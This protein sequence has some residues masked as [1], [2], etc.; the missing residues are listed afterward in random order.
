MTTLRLGRLHAT[1]GAL[2]TLT[3]NTLLDVLQRHACGDW[4]ESC[5]DDRAVNEDALSDGSRLLSACTVEGER[6]WI[7]AEADCGATTVLLSAE[8]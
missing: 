2:A 1:P 5:D 6:I 4:G 3:P 8:Y 7:I